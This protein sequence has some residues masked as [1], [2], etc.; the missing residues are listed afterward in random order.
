M[1][2][3]AYGFLIGKVVGSR[4]HGGGHLHWLTMVEPAAEGHPPYRVAALLGPDVEYQIIVDA[5]KTGPQKLKDLIR[6]LRSKGQTQ[7]FLVKGGDGDPSMDFVDWGLNG[8]KPS[9]D[10]LH[11]EFGKAVEAAKT[12]AAALLAVFGTGYPVNPATGGSPG[13][14]YTGIENV[15]MN[16]GTPDRVGMGGQYRE[17]GR[18]QDGGL[19]F[20]TKSMATAFFVKFKSQILDT[21][22]NG[23]PNTTGVTAIDAHLTRARQILATDQGVAAAFAA[24]AAM[25]PPPAYV[26]ADPE[27]DDATETFIPDNDTYFNT[28][29]V[30]QQAK[31]K[32][33]GRVP[34]PRD[35]NTVSMN[36]TSIA[37]AD[38]PGHRTSGGVET[39]DFDVIGDSG[40]VTAA[41]YQGEQAVGD[42][43]TANAKASQ[44][45]FLYH[46]GDV[47][48]YY[49]EKQFYYGQFAEV[50]RDYPAPIF[51]IPGN[52]DGLTHDVG[53]VSLDSFMAAFCAAAPGPWDGFGGIRRSAMTQPGVYFTL[54]APLVSIIG[55]YSNC[56]ESEPWLNDEQFAFLLSELKRLK[57]E[58]D[59]NQRAVLLAIH[60]M[61][62]W[63]P[64]RNDPVSEA[65][66]AHCQEAG[67]WPDAVLAG[68]AHL[69]Q[70]IVRQTGVGGA[71]K[72]I[73][74]FICGNGGYKIVATQKLGG[75]YVAGL[76]PRLTAVVN[77][78]GYMRARITKTADH[79]TL[80][81]ECHSTKQSGIADSCSVDLLAGK[82][83]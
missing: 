79:M 4:P 5:E 18:N 14:G 46:V 75:A 33:H 2:L 35:A 58:R 31:G 78:E 52:H 71:P 20:L 23:N 39:I 16:Q 83:L 56:G 61:P 64:G 17:N 24:R 51:A 55:L 60:H 69:Y 70:R 12:D 63:F 45:A 54:D 25:A 10:K 38:V 72:D 65:I 22:G 68:H 21:N 47:V 3:P 6:S 66:D 81:F 29:Y 15:H 57:P 9:D 82:L 32:T 1:P 50:F 59:A 42:L 26:F 53:M 41:Y 73:P 49:G 67:L 36:L 44:P 77:E 34:A 28:D 30:Q 37:G 19:I 74:Y 13:T 8:F 27:T 43:I 62:R 80:S 76:G 48:Y 7:N 11:T 40:A